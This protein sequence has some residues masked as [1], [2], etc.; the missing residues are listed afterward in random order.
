[1]KKGFAIIMQK[2]K[3]ITDPKVIKPN[4]KIETILKNE[5][6]YSTIIKKMKNESKLNI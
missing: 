2:D 5:K 4:T 6:I 3:I 1:M